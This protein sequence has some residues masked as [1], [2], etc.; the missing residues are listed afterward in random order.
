MSGSTY[1]ARY[2]EP[3]YED[4]VRMELDLAAWSPSHL[5]L[6]LFLKMHSG[7]GVGTKV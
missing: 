5:C 6:V 3:A 7:N 4:G 1:C 2:E